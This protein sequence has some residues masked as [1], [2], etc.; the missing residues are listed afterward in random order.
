MLFQDG[1]HVRSGCD[2]GSGLGAGGGQGRVY[3]MPQPLDS[4]GRC[5]WWG[6]R[7]LLHQSVLIPDAAAWRR[8]PYVFGEVQAHPPHTQQACEASLCSSPWDPH[9]LSSFPLPWEAL[10]LCDLL[11]IDFQ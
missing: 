11:R 6:P 3:V 10:W 9:C 5:R 8:R 2:E 1:V 4:S 7:G